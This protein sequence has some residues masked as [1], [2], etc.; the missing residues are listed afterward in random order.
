MSII[1]KIKNK[2]ERVQTQKEISRLFDKYKN[3]EKLKI[4][5][6]CG[7]RILKNWINIDLNYIPHEYI[8]G[9]TE[10]FYSEEIRGNK[11]DFYKIDFT[12]AGIPLPDNSVDVIFHEDFIEHLNQRDQI[13]FLA[14][15]FRVLKN[16]GIHRIN[17]PNLIESMKRHSDFSKGI[18]GVFIKEWKKHGHLN[19]L[20][21]KTLEEMAKMIGYSSVI[22]NDKDKSISNLIPSEYRPAPNSKNRSQDG[23]IFADLIK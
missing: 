1:K 20:T 7:S 13:R 9:Y 10:K 16:G 23:N 14:E 2:I 4:H 15:T 5:F 21:Q 8:K 18:K 6:G 17:T 22:F 12:K 19:I 3:K 11:K